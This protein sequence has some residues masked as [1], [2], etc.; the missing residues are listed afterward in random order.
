MLF[1][2]LKRKEIMDSQFNGRRLVSNKREHTHTLYTYSN[3]DEF[4]EYHVKQKKLTHTHTETTVL[5]ALALLVPPCGWILDSGALGG[6]PHMHFWVT[7]EG[8]NGS[9]VA[10]PEGNG[11][12]PLASGSLSNSLDCPPYYHSA[13]PNSTYGP[14]RTY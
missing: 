1:L 6:S 7:S 14:R 9:S 4:Q 2:S 8:R 12:F 5:P 3:M 10:T 11:K 13:S